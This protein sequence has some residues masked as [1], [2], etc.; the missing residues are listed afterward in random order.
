MIEASANFGY[1]KKTPPSD[2]PYVMKT[3]SILATA[4]LLL[5]TSAFG[6]T[7]PLVSTNPFNLQNL[8]VSQF[9]IPK[10]WVQI[11]SPTSLVAVGMY[12]ATSF[13]HVLY[14]QDNTPKG[15]K[16]IYI[17]HQNDEGTGS[18]SVLKVAQLTQ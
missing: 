3:L 11:A 9:S 12:G 5:L 7:L 16:D 13:T 1:P 6:I 17:V 10:N 4:S 15:T 8:V 2:I 14:F 18:Y